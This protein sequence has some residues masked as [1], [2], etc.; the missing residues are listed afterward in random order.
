MPVKSIVILLLLHLLHE[1]KINNKYEYNTLNRQT[2][3]E[4]NHYTVFNSIQQFT[5]PIVHNNTNR[6]LFLI[7]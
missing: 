5:F 3:V 6:W 1:S 7:E 2:N 4:I